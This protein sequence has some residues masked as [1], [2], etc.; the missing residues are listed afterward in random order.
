[1]GI[2][3]FKGFKHSNFIMKNMNLPKFF[4]INTHNNI[5]RVPFR[6]SIDENVG[7]VLD[8]VF[9]VCVVGIGLDVKFIDQDFSTDLFFKFKLTY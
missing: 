8:W 7:A 6:D 3:E 4:I 9:H 2:K 5:I 1:M